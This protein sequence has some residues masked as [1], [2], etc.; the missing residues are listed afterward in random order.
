[1]TDLN[2]RLF[3]G[4]GIGENATDFL[5]AIRRRNLLSPT[6]KDEEKLEFFELSLKSGSYAKSWYN[7]LPA[8]DKDTFKN[9]VTAFQK[10]WPEK[11]MAEKEKGELQEEL[12]SLTLRPEDVGVRIEEDGIQE[13][14]H[15]RWVT[16]AAELAARVE[17]GGRLIPQVLKNI[18]DSLLLRLGPKR[19]TWPELVQTMK[20][21]P[22]TDIASV[23]RLE[24]RLAG[25]EAL[26]DSASATIAAL[27]RTPTRGLTAA[28][29][30]LAAS[31]PARNDPARRNLFPAPAARTYRPDAERWQMIL[32]A[33]IEMRWRQIVQSI[34]SRT[35]RAAP[36]TTSINVVADNEDT[37]EGDVF[38]TAE[39]PAEP[40]KRGGAVRLSEYET[41]P[42]HTA[43]GGARVPECKEESL[44]DA[45]LESRTQHTSGREEGALPPDDVT[46]VIPDAHVPVYNQSHI[47]DLYS[48][49]SRER[50]KKSV[51]F[52]QKVLLRTDGGGEMEVETVVDDGAMAG[53]LDADAYAAAR[54]TLG[55]LA[56]SPQD[57]LLI[58]NE[59]GE[60]VRVENAHAG[61]Q[62][63][64]SPVM[65]VA[66]TATRANVSG[67]SRAPPARQA[68][69]TADPAPREQ[70]DQPVPTD[71]SAPKA[72]NKASARTSNWWRAG[73]GTA[74]TAPTHGTDG[75]GEDAPPTRQVPEHMLPLPVYPDEH[76][77]TGEKAVDDL[78]MQTA[79][80]TEIRE[81]QPSADKRA[82]R[83]RGGRRE[84]ERK[85]A[86]AQ[87]PPAQKEELASSGGLDRAADVGEEKDGKRGAQNAYARAG[88]SAQRRRAIAARREERR[89]KGE[90]L[91]RA[92]AAAQRRAAAEAKA[93]R[94]SLVGESG[95]PRAR[96]TKDQRK[97]WRRMRALGSGGHVPPRVIN[98]E[99][100]SRTPSR[101]VP[102][103]IDTET[104]TRP[105]RQRE[106]AKRSP[107]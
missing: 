83:K 24:N 7:K 55:E 107:I 12:L 46:T 87:D 80:G 35:A 60:I 81:A 29:S 63:K 45:Q 34:R 44:G 38:G 59:R 18:P 99:G 71:V 95:V 91:E 84:K 28:F 21:V 39:V 32:A 61:A 98:S 64:A 13:W 40:G 17:D 3:K 1:M 30:G 75:G 58:R 68:P 20:D 88:S 90:E 76:P 52:I 69:P 70:I 6:W 73:L 65:S 103:H 11:E 4:D 79:S 92:E 25:M 10:Q 72:G 93:R 97:A 104:E 67:G 86:D 53:A 51:P 23:R 49:G 26:I 66:G 43:G 16:K 89:R 19:G 15:V 47:L 102:P 77:V 14:G 9:L 31:S 36:A 2:P 57:V 94:V 85:R 56:W 100:D 41:A 50:N 96:W 27:Q 48:V 33:P 54:Q 74:S 8:T 82:K 78:P 62:G 22:A 5:N 106:M 42:E 37:S 101:E 105:H